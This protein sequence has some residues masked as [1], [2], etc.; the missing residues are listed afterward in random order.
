[1]QAEI[2]TIGD[3]LLIG[4]T[5]D[6]NSAWI[7]HALS[8]IGVRVTKIS[9]IQDDELEIKQQL[10]VSIPKADIVIITGGLGPTKDDLTKKVLNEYFGGNLIVNEKVQARNEAYF[11][12]RNRPNLAV[13]QQQ[14][15]V[16]DNCTVLF[17]HNG[18][19]PGMWFEKS[20][21]IVVS[22]PGVPYEM[23]ALMSDEVLPRLRE[24]KQLKGLY[25]RTIQ[26]TGIGESFLAEYIKDW[27]N[28]VRKNGLSLAYLPSPGIVKL[29][30]SSYSGEH[31]KVNRAIENL[32][33][34]IPQYFF[35]ENDDSFSQ[36]IGKILMQRKQTIGTAESCTSGKLANEI[37]KIPGASAYYNGSIVA[38][39]Y[40]L[41]EKL[42][43]I[44]SALLDKQG[45][46]SKECVERMAM[47]GKEKLS[48]DYCIATSGIAGPTGGTSEKPVG[49]VWIAIAGP[50]GVEAQRFQFG[51]LREV[52]IELSC[53]NALRLLLN[54]LKNE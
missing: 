31:E 1:M 25:C 50:N 34:L 23:K 40:A 30:L 11:A 12:T 9:S 20:N 54:K 26:T 2:I 38:Y 42:L 47:N 5:I 45:A 46:V 13:N 21:T 3:E 49:T 37:V 24:N 48:V 53:S 28:D 29:R 14:A 51:Q 35:A 44:P 41:K 22:L 17:N 43:D 18:T 6:T 16:P 15:L 19:A 8:Q 36:I 39:S 7:G 27:E 52:N 32:K 4:Q 10:D 33:T